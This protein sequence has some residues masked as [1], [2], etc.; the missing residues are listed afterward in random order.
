MIK[1]LL[2]DPVTA[3]TWMQ[4]TLAQ[5][6]LE[7]DVRRVVRLMIEAVRDEMSPDE[8]ANALVLGES[9]TVEDVYAMIRA[10]L[11]PPS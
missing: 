3:V 6:A 8:Y 11:L 5:S 4:V 9:L 7:P 2:G 10:E 1:R